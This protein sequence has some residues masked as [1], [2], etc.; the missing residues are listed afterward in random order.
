M[1]YKWNAADSKVEWVTETDADALETAI[2][3]NGDATLTFNGVAD[4]YYELV[5][6]APP[7]G[8]NPLT[9]PIAFTLAQD[10]DPTTG[11]PIGVEYVESVTNSSGS[12][13][14]GTGG[15]G[16]TVIYA[17][18]AALLVVSAV[19]LVTRKRMRVAAR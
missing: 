10:T 6:T 19:L 11:I 15:M 17:A 4:G 7:A 14:P 5:E 8:Y 16:T 18:G 2:D 9:G 1:Y 13:L 12:I 3:A